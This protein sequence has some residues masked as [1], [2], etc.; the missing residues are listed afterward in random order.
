MLP[1]ILT[2]L[3]IFILSVDS[4][5]R[6]RSNKLIFLLVS[7]FIGGLAGSRVETLGGYDTGVYKLMYDNVRGYIDVFSPEYFLLLTTERGYVFLMALIKSL[8]FNFNYFLLT[9]G[10]SCGVALF[11]IF[12]KYT[13]YAFIVLAIFLSKGYLYYFFTAQRQVIAM[14]ICWFALTFVI[15]KKFLPFFLMVVLASLFHSSAIVFLVIYFIDRL[16]FNNRQVIALIIASI[17]TGVLKLGAL[18]GIALSSILPF[19][20]E[21]LSGYVTGATGG[22]NVLNFI[23]LI[24]ILFF[25]LSNRDNITNRTPYY[26]L[27]FNIYLIYVLITFA[28]FDFSF[29]ARLK[30]YFVLGYIVVIASLLDVTKK[31]EIG[32]GVLVLILLYCFAVMVRE[33]LV[34]DDGKGY[35]PYKSFLFN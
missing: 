16:R 22:I 25:V 13:K 20:G 18:L 7:L 14:C 8:G 35:L 32:I 11:Y 2:Y 26:N 6:N 29:I 19:G 10:L 3:V 28:F 1:Y 9:V 34:F 23:E 31:K 15:N 17:L 30:G 21:K 27:F 24:P 33:L 12:S 4:Y 5:F